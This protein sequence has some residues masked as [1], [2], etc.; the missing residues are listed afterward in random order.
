MKKYKYLYVNGSSFTAGG[1]LE[2]IKDNVKKAYK[3]LFG[4]EWKHE[5]D[6]AWPK[7]LAKQLGLH[8]FDESK[9]GGGPERVIRMTYDY[10]RRG[11]AE[12][13]LFILEL[14]SAWNRVDIYSNHFNKHLICNP[15]YDMENGN[16]IYKDVESTQG[17]FEYNDSN[18][19]N[20]FVKPHLIE[21]FTHFHNLNEYSKK[22]TNSVVGLYSTME[23]LDLKFYISNSGVDLGLHTFFKDYAK[24]MVPWLLNDLY[25]WA[26]QKHKKIS[27][28]TNGILTDGHPG[29]FAHKEWADILYNFLSKDLENS[30][31]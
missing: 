4:L 12:N 29:Y 13:T 24:H 25:V 7:L 2:P 11:D 22:V 20:Q 19:I 28:E 5:R 23:A 31:N 21:Y 16:N 1:G 18:E 30:E 8:L 15:N 14:P 6:V 26:E 27:D 10:L 17:Y 9:S 3:E